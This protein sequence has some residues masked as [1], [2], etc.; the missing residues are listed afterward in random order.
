MKKLY[1]F[2]FTLTTPF[3]FSCLL[4]FFKIFIWHL[5]YEDKW[6]HIKS[7]IK[8]IAK[9]IKSSALQK[10]KKHFFN[11]TNRIKRRINGGNFKSIR[12][13]KL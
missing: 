11:Q 8:L 2:N 10:S 13:L 7:S 1:F 6:M 9:T 3:Y 5:N 4:C 12:E